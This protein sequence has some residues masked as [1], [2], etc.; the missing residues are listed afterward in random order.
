MSTGGM[1]VRGE[2]RALRRRI[3]R[4]RDGLPAERRAAWS[5]SIAERLL[6]RPELLRAGT[7]HLFASFGSEVETLPIVE[8]LLASGRRPVL[9]VVL[10]ET[11]TM[12]HAAIRGL[13][14]LVPGFKGI[15]E[16][17]DGCP[18]CDPG[19]IDLV[20]VPGVAFDRR[21]GRLGYGGGFYDRFLAGCPAPRIALAFSMQIVEAVPCEECDLPIDVILTELEEIAPGRG[22]T[23]AP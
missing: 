18:S 14:D 9:P 23:P 7:V 1:D 22:G 6:A 5:R 13:D 19:E 11:W 2:K 12:K 10:R 4:E 16:P 15:L 20:I 3:L 8:R 17:A 21:G